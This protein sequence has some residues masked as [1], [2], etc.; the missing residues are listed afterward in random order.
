MADPT[1]NP[2]DPLARI[3]GETA[4]ALQALHDFE[5]MG[6]GRSVSLLTKKYRESPEY[7]GK[8]PPSTSLDTLTRWSTRFH[9]QDRIARL[10]EIRAAER[11]AIRL[12][13][14]KALEDADWTQG[15]ALREKVEGLLAEMEKFSTARVQ[16]TTGPDGEKLKI[17][18][19][20]FKPSLG[21]MSMAAKV[22]SELQRLA[23]G[24]ATQNSRL[25]DR[26]GADRDLPVIGIEVV[27]PL[28]PETA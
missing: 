9:W 10:L 21:Q 24:A 17:I 4:R 1:F 27:N 14:F 3:P 7:D 20:K 22:A 12:A 23:V 5:A 2:A 25:V 26:E 8:K 16:E 15:Q 13:R 28:T 11:E 19:V 6:G 18:T